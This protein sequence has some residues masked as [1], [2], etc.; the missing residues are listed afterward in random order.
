ME[1][2]VD[3]YLEKP[4]KKKKLDKYESLAPNKP[5]AAKK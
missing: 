5:K 3:H 2:N 4:K 1:K